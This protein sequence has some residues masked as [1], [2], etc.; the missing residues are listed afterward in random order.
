MNHKQF[1]YTYI[2]IILMIILIAWGCIAIVNRAEAQGQSFWKV[3]S[4]R[5]KQTVDSWIVEV[6][7]LIVNENATTTGNL[8]IGGSATTTGYM[9]T[10]T[11]TGYVGDGTVGYG[12][13]TLIQWLED[14][15]NSGIMDAVDVTDEGTL[16]V[17]WTL[18]EI[19][20]QSNQLIVDT[21][22]STSDFLTDD[23]VNYLKWVSGADLTLSTTDAEGNER[24]IAHF[25]A[26]D[27]DIWELHEEPAIN[28]RESSIEDALEKNFPTTVSSGI[29]VS[30]D[31]DV[32]N[33][34]DVVVSAGVYY[35]DM[36]E[37]HDYEAFVSSTTPMQ[38]WFHSSG[39]WTHDT[40]AEIDN[41]QYDDG[42]DLAPLTAGRWVKSCWLASQANGTEIL[43]WI[44]PQ[45]QFTVQA[46]ALVASCPTKPP[47]LE[48]QPY[49][50]AVVMRQGDTAFPTAGGDRW[51]DVR[52]T[53]T[54]APA[55]NVTD[56]G[57]LSGL[58][59]DDHTQYLLTDGTRDLAGDWSAGGFDIDNIGNSTTT[60]A[61]S[62][63]LY[64]SGPTELDGSTT[65]ITGNLDLEGGFQK[66]GG[67]S[68]TI[69]DILDRPIIIGS[70]TKLT[71][72]TVQVEI[73]EDLLIEANIGLR[74]TDFDIA[75]VTSILS[76]AS[77]A[78][79]DNA[80]DILTFFNA[81]GRFIYDAEP[82][83]GIG[84]IFFNF[85]TQV[86]ATTTNMAL[87]GVAV[88]RANPTITADG[89]TLNFTGGLPTFM[90]TPSFSRAN[91]GVFAG[92]SS[93]KGYQSNLALGAGVS[94]DTRTSFEIVG[95]AG[96]GII[97]NQIGINILDLTS[98]TN[99]DIGIQIDGADTYALWLGAGSAVTTAADGITFGSGAD[100]NLYRSAAN[101][102]KTDD[103][104]VVNGSVTT[105]SDCGI[106]SGVFSGERSLVVSN[107]SVAYGNGDILRGIP[108]AC[109]GVV[110]AISGS[111][112]NCSSGVNEISMELRINNVSQTCDVPQ[113]TTAYDT[114]H[115]TCS[116]S[117]SAD[118]LVGCFTKTETGV[119]TGINCALYVSYD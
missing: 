90:D 22:A 110:T 48:R 9:S 78:R 28:V 100:V 47:G 45:E 119:V 117:F 53:V 1:L 12:G 107:Q 73:M 57:Q 88:F 13:E 46:N 10:G 11:T 82:F 8:I 17:S 109:D 33:A 35:H 99:T 23:A 86:V 56:H 87:S 7:E 95:K 60:N 112:E 55:G 2:L 81:G 79:I 52:P 49:L 92:G 98:A 26:Q 30:E 18:G 101:T 27:G 50:T 106:P 67:T 113:L 72:E 84:P 16:E 44:Y 66:W 111:C 40:N 105:D 75:G 102:L 91:S 97:G 15:S 80:L 5:L 68:H 93:Y 39:D 74:P 108:Q 116:V 54:S 59:D 85:N 31:T 51:I 118:D 61:T 114:D 37:K 77:D 34:L 24:S 96:T 3:I 71:I 64:V 42:N 38:R 62:S 83:L 63:T 58:A 104:L 89:V 21:V 4:G 103:N 14:V 36:Q 70:A 19:F 76:F 69:F 20:D 25:A 43:H 94:M 115:A 29:V 6:R 65:T 32:T 41:T